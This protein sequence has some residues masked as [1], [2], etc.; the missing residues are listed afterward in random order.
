MTAVC[1]SKHTW[2]LWLNIY[3]KCKWLKM[4]SN[5]VS[6]KLDTQPHQFQ[7][8]GVKPCNSR[9]SQLEWCSPLTS[10]SYKGSRQPLFSVA[11]SRG[12]ETFKR[13]DSKWSVV[14]SLSL[15]PSSVTTVEIFLCSHINKIWKYFLNKC[16]SWSFPFKN[17]LSSYLQ[18]FE[19]WIIFLSFKIFLVYFPFNYTKSIM[20]F[21][22]HAHGEHWYHSI[23]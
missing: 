22:L 4:F 1:T 5:Q 16:N 10:T 23:S 18:I 19:K 3:D 2:Q 6:S 11:E 17:V 13:K 12:P 21:N 15:S 7:G 20:H 9:F 8:L 14:W